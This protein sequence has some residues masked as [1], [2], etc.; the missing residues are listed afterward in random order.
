MS[1]LEKALHDFSQAGI[2][3]LVHDVGRSLCH[4]QYVLR[5]FVV[6]KKKKN[7]TAKTSTATDNA[8]KG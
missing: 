1:G 7:T 5:E 2:M 3:A 4:L 6:K 8:E